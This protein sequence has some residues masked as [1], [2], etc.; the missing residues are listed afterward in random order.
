MA[1]AKVNYKLTESQ[2]KLRKIVN[3]LKSQ[4][5]Q[6]QIQNL[7]VSRLSSGFE[8]YNDQPMRKLSE[9]YVEKRRKLIP[10]NRTSP[11]FVDDN[12]SRL[13]FTGDLLNGIKARIREKA[14][15]I[16]ILVNVTGMRAPY[17]GK[18]GEIGTIKSNKQVAQSL[19]DMGRPV[20]LLS[21]KTQKKFSRL[22]TYIIKER[23]SKM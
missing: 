12:K 17:K 5:F 23:I 14:H 11:N 10:Y 6:L 13:T 22:I 15:T 9:V 21:N 7:F 16:E 4:Q 20:L 18:N 1:K 19:R 3:D 2:K 8:L